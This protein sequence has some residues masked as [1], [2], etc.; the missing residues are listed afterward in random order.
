VI[1]Q[2]ENKAIKEQIDDLKESMTLVRGAHSGAKDFWGYVIGA[3][4]LL[5][6]IGTLAVLVVSRIH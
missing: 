2:T 1:S 3:L 4:G 6:A 5:V